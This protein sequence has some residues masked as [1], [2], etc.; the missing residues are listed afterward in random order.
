LIYQDLLQVF[1][2]GSNPFAALQKPRTAMDEIE[3]LPHQRFGHFP[4]SQI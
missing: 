4:V 2:S 3:A 1:Q